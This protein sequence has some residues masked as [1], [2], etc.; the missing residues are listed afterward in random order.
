LVAIVKAGNIAAWTFSQFVL[1]M[2]LHAR[3]EIQQPFDDL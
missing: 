1:V 2:L 3:L